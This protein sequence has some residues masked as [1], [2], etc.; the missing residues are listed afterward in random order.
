[1]S[2]A[3][4]SSKKKTRRAF[5]FSRGWFQGWQIGKFNIGQRREMI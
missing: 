1:M 5:I 4:L 3:G 2:G